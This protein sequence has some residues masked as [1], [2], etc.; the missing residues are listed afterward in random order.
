MVTTCLTEAV[1]NAQKAPH[2]IS[3]G[4]W[5]PGGRARAT[6]D[7]EI[8]QWGKVRLRMTDCDHNP[9]ILVTRTNNSSELKEADGRQ[10]H[11]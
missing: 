10:N 9:Q 6:S 8:I 4:G 1:K 2:L 7:M 3:E 5:G 11:D